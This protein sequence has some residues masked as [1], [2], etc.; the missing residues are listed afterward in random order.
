MRLRV[1]IENIYSGEVW[2]LEGAPRQVRAEVLLLFPWM[3][4]ENPADRDDLQAL[5]E[6]LGSQQAFS[7]EHLSS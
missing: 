4:S 6:D 5:L 2:L 3:R 7:V 1:R